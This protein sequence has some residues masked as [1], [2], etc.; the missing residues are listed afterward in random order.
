[1][2]SGGS[3]LLGTKPDLEFRKELEAW[4][5]ENWRAY[6]SAKQDRNCCPECGEPYEDI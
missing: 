4:P 2:L 3:F 6:F 1:M 5:V